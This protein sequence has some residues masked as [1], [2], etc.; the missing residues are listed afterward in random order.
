M[1]VNDTAQGANFLE[2]ANEATKEIKKGKPPVAQV[3]IKKWGTAKEKAKISNPDAG[4]AFTYS[5]Y[6]ASSDLVGAYPED[7]V[8][9]YTDSDVID[10]PYAKTQDEARLTLST[11]LRMVGMNNAIASKKLAWYYPNIRSGD[12]VTFSDGQL[13]ATSVSNSLEFRGLQNGA[14][15]V[16]SEGTQVECG[17]DKARSISLTSATF[18][19]NS[20][21]AIAPNVRIS[22]SSSSRVEGDF[23]YNTS[24]RRYSYG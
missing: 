21:S 11:D 20:D 19:R 23:V 8:L 22:N 14:L 9:R 6:Y 1:S 18:A 4:K 17:Y 7:I 13:R 16:V 10:L 12:R 5:K 24:R 3:Q 15:M 2:A